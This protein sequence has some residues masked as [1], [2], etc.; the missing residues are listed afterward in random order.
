[1]EGPHDPTP[2]FTT[3]VL[4][5]LWGCSVDW[6]Y[7]RI[8]NGELVAYNLG[9]WRIDPADAEAFKASRRHGPPPPPP[10]RRKPGPK[11]KPRHLTKGF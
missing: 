1:M 8:K 2:F 6:I 11:R 4:A 10:Q 9:G 5:S 3:A 7:A